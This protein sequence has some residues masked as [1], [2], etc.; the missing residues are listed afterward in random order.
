MT[1]KTVN[2]IVSWLKLKI[3]NFQVKISLLKKSSRKSRWRSPFIIPI[4]IY[5]STISQCYN[6]DKNKGIVKAEN[7][8][9]WPLENNFHFGM[10]SSSSFNFILSD[11]R[12]FYGSLMPTDLYFNELLS[13]RN[14]N[15]TVIAFDFI[16]NIV[17]LFSSDMIFRFTR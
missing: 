5:F 9:I 7:N 4:F 14:Y 1:M 10:S 15:L 6:K 13:S 16:N 12:V 2:I 17:F 11:A 3:K 8:N